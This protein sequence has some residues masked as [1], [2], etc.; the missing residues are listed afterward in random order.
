MSVK[1]ITLKI[2]QRLCEDDG[3]FFLLLFVFFGFFFYPSLS[4]APISDDLTEI[5]FSR[6]FVE[7]QGFV[8]VWESRRWPLSAIFHYA[9]FLLSPKSY[10]PYHLLNLLVHFFNLILLHTILKTLGIAKRRWVVLLFSLHPTQVMTVVWMIQLKTL[11]SFSFILLSFY[12]FVLWSQLKL[13]V[14]PALFYLSFFYLCSL[15]SK[16]NLLLF[17]FLLLAVDYYFFG[18]ILRFKNYYYLLPLAAIGILNLNYF[19]HSDYYPLSLAA[20]VMPSES[21]SAVVWPVIQNVT[22]TF[23]FY[24]RQLFLPLSLMPIYPQFSPTDLPL[25]ATLFSGFCLFLAVS[26]FVRSKSFVLLAGITFFLLPVSGVIAAPFMQLFPVADNHLYPLVPFV[27]ILMASG[28]SLLETRFLGKIKAVTPFFFSLIALCFALRGYAYQ[29]HFSNQEK[30][31]QTIIRTNPSYLFA[32]LSLG[33]YYQD[34]NQCSKAIPHYQQA[35]N[36]YHELWGSHLVTKEH[37]ENQL[38]NCLP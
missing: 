35:I 32:H 28:W 16:S 12:S 14:L 29:F 34:L 9:L 11:L 21:S 27:L 4:F 18:K 30:Y 8:Q 15:L 5:F 26:A 22:H 17:P 25:S 24:L 2:W 38:K 23:S 36:R 7:K 37:I 13:K 6:D 1:P 33:D 19:A 20:A 10:W 3:L 31:L